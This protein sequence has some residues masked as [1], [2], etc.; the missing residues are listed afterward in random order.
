ML[1]FLGLVTFALA[2]AIPAKTD[3]TADDSPVKRL[4]RLKDL[5]LTKKAAT[6][7]DPKK[8]FGWGNPFEKAE[9]ISEA[10]VGLSKDQRL[11][12]LKRL[13][14]PKKDATAIDP[15]KG[16]GWGNPLEKAE[17]VREAVGY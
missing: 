11:N 7:I 14:L 15:K 17:E 9:E 1:S 16:Y 8:G 2:T 4:E 5:G 12:R 10:V 13:A 6:A 3:A